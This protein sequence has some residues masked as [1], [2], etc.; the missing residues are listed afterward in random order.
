M[1]DQDKSKQL[2]TKM[3]GLSIFAE[4]VGERQTRE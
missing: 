3:G 2:V 1:A 4:C